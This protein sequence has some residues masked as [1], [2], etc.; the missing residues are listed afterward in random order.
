MK[1]LAAVLV[2]TNQPLVLQELIIPK[3]KAGQVLI[4]IAYS[5]ICSTQLLELDGKRGPDR[6]LPHCLGHEGSGRVLD[7]G[8]A[9]TKVKPGDHVVLSWIKGSGCNVPG[10][11]YQNGETI[12]NAGGVTTLQ[13][14]AVVSENRVTKLSED[15]PLDQAALLGCAVP[16][17]CGSVIN[18]ARVRP[19]ESIVVFGVGG[20]GLNAVAAA[21]LCGA[22]SIVAVDLSESRLQIATR[23]GATATISTDQDLLEKLLK[24]QPRGFDHAIE[25]TGNSFIMA[26]ALQ[27][28]RQQGG[29]AVIIGNAVHGQTID[30]DPAELNKGKRVLGTWGGDNDPD[31][32]YPIYM[33]LAKN[34]LLPLS[35]L[36]TEPY[37]LEHVNQAFEDLR[38]QRVARPLIKMAI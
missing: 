24:I 28:V 35:E 2:K 34:Q 4:E 17:G 5:G 37:K 18:T 10:T 23:L 25:A 7:I 27:S 26:T 22:V 14:H 9:I 12:V 32:N 30:L 33:N 21:K 20:V 11:T 8:D 29:N 19:G 31:L 1:T 38:Y 3:L 16:T 15:F 6:F 13:R 36:I